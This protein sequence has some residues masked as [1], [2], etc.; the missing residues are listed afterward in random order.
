MTFG[1]YKTA[2]ILLPKTAFVKNHL[3]VACYVE[4]QN[5]WVSQ[6]HPN[7][8]VETGNTFTFILAYE[9]IFCANSNQEH[10]PLFDTWYVPYKEV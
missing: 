8:S 1:F 6:M 4:K 2:L 10:E 7:S 5:I 3:I 9:N